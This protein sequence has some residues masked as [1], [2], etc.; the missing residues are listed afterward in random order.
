M[1]KCIVN[2]ISS[3]PW[4]PSGQERLLESLKDV[5]FDGDVLAFDD[6]N[7]KDCP[8]HSDVPYAF[9]PYVITEAKNRGYDLILWLDAS[10]W[11]IKSLD[12]IFKLMEE[13]GCAIQAGGE[14]LGL[15]CSDIALKKFGISREEAIQQYISATGLLGLNMKNEKSVEFLNRWLAYAKEKICFK[16]DWRNVNHS[17][18]N[19]D[20]V[21]GHRHD[22]TVG[23]FIINQLKMPLQDCHTL[24]STVGF[25]KKP[26]SYK[27]LPSSVC[28]CARGM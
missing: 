2:Y 13:K 20:R 12:S 17:V 11:A 18:S 26:E 8:S 6:V 15:W 22:M 7:F 24:F 9:K 4:Y 5:N 3:T 23:S 1:K 21:Q 27:H 25:Y 19:D 14:I 16:G 28:F 10:F